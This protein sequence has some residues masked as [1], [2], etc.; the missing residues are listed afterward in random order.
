MTHHLPA[1]YALATLPVTTGAISTDTSDLDANEVR[2][3][4][5]GFEL[6]AYC[7]R[8]G[9]NERSPVVLVVQEIFG[10]HE[11][12]KDVCRR[13]AKEGYYAIAPELYA[14]QGDPAATGDM[15]ELIDKIVSR[16]PD[17]Q[18][19]K[20]LD[21][22]AEFA[23]SS[24]EG[25]TERLGICGFCWG[26]RITWLYSAHQPK[27]KAGAAWYG[28]LRPG[29]YS[30]PEM[31]PKQPVDVAGDLHGAIL[32][33]Y[34]GQDESIPLSTVEQMREALRAAGR[35][36]TSQIIVYPEAG[37][38]FHADYRASYHAESARDAWAKML[39][40]FKKYGVV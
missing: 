21:A 36:R 8:P 25:D 17:K 35:D 5:D 39:A 16:V 28:K 31:Q 3:S 18:V 27:L 38:A 30:K 12:I 40:W 32:G 37:H 19:L 34:G 23:R 2:I 33:L 9:K 4:S 15:A 24:G 7:A 1:G 14:R 22:A 29:P 6:P 13:L 10:V 26:G 11:H 20:D